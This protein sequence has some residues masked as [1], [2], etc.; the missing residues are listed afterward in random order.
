[1]TVDVRRVAPADHA[2]FAAIVNEVL[3]EVPTTVEDMAWQDATY[4]GGVRFTEIGA[5]HLILGMP[6][7]LGP[8]GIATVAAEVV[9]PL[10][11]R[12]G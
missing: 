1:M 10:R 2:T 6:A 5:T 9:A 3:P 12:L 11:D 8:H 7:G 4:P